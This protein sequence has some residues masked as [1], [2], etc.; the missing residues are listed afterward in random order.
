MFDVKRLEYGKVLRLLEHH[1]LSDFSRKKVRTFRPSGNRE[2]IELQFRELEQLARTLETGFEPA[3]DK[4]HDIMDLLK[5]AAP[6]NS[7]L[8]P[9][10]LQEIGE[11]IRQLSK[12]KKQIEAVEDEM[13]L[14]SEAIGKV[15]IPLDVLEKIDG[16]IDEHGRVRDDATQRLHDIEGKL[17]YLREGIESLLDRYIHDPETRNFLQDGHITL[18]EDRYVIPIKHNYRGRIPGVIHAHSGSDKTVFVE[19][20]SV[21]DMN[22]EIRMLVKEREKEIRRILIGLTRAVGKKS[23]ELSIVQD[24]LC[25]YDILMAKNHY[26]THAGCCFPEFSH[27]REI[28]LVGARHPLLQGKVV[29]IDFKIEGSTSGV[30]ITGPNTG[31][32]TVCLK[33]IG[34]FVLLAQSGI[35][36][37]AKSIKS[38]VFNSVYSDIGDES[39]IEQ[40]LSTFSGHIK[41]IRGIVRGA[42]PDSLV[43]IDELGAGTDPIEGGALGTAILDYLIENRIVWVVTTHFSF[44]KMHAIKNQNTAVASVEFDSETCSPTYRLIM[45]IPGRSNALE[46][47]EHLG[48]HKGIIGKTRNYL[49]DRDRSID[50]IFKNLARMEKDLTSRE[51]NILKYEKELGELK[52]R[53]WKN[54]KALEERENALSTQFRTQY[55]QLVQEFRKRLEGSIKD[56]REREGARESIK[57]ARDEMKKVDQDFN[58]FLEKFIQKE[59]ESNAE[60]V[61]K[62]SDVMAVGDFVRVVTVDGGTLRGKIVGM[63]RDKVTLNAGSLKLTVN[64]DR[65]QEVYENKTQ[66]NRPAQDWDFA[67]SGERKTVHE[68]DIRGMRFEEAMDEVVRFLDNAV[69]SNLHTLSIIHG[70]GTG[71]LREGV[72]NTLKKHRD[73]HHFEYARPEQGGYGCTIVVLKG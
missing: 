7:A 39:S 16:A 53:Y 66:K 70:L 25:H 24:V 71:A 45:G 9:E 38:Y 12:L 49:G 73:V 50:G 34:L 3:H 65:V 27:R 28:E 72:Q 1:C 47:A 4:Y 63:S 56:I 41:N 35:P 22:N 13:S 36:V 68:C 58:E 60:R 67:S 15:R 42:D 54:V 29:P 5:R 51:K 64:R 6:Q 17:V 11:N 21:V 33:T 46:I 26:M 30:V 59:R 23:E 43:L 62:K 10:E 32:K 57:A 48:L 14:L 55:S 20:Y 31:G 18:K 52:S 40:S 69:L 19:P 37:P 61:Q 2:D 44:I 8:T